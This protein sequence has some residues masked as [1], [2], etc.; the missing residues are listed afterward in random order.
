MGSIGLPLRRTTLIRHR[1]TH[2]DP[3][4]A[5][6]RIRNCDYVRGTRNCRQSLRKQD[7][8]WLRSL[9]T[10]LKMGQQGLYGLQL[11]VSFTHAD[12]AL[13]RAITAGAGSS[14]E[15]N[16]NHIWQE[17]TKNFLCL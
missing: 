11:R 17:M 12:R 15:N 10:A 7:H 4:E 8:E 13:S 16:H 9:C 2:M 1:N 3:T 6:C 14:Y 5:T